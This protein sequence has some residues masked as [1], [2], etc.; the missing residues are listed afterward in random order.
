M[1]GRNLSRIRD[2]LYFIVFVF[3]IGCKTISMIMMGWFLRLLVLE[4]SLSTRPEY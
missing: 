3:L 2:R 4:V 1:P